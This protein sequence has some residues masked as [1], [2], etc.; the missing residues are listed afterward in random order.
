MQDGTASITL[1]GS[2]IGKGVKCI[3]DHCCKDEFSGLKR[4]TGISGQR[5]Y[6]AMGLN[7]NIVVAY[8]NCGDPANIRPNNALGW[9]VN[10]VC[11]GGV[12]VPSLVMCDP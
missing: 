9:G 2:W 4:N 11:M 8:G 10:P 5:F 1:D 7:F 6:N 3:F 12:E